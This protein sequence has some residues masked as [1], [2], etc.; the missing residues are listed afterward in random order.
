MQ[1]DRRHRAD[2]RSRARDGYRKCADVGK[3]KG[4]ILRGLSARAPYFHN[5]AAK[6]LD[7][8]VEFIT[9]ASCLVHRPAK[10]KTWLRSSN[11]VERV[12][13]PGGHSLMTARLA[14]LI[15]P[16]LGVPPLALFFS[17]LTKTFESFRPVL[18]LEAC[19][20]HPLGGGS[21]RYTGNH[22]LK[23]LIGY[24][25]VWRKR[26]LLTLGVA[27]LVI[28]GLGLQNIAR[29][30]RR[31][32]ARISSRRRRPSPSVEAQKVKW[33]AIHKCGRHG[34]RDP[35]C[36]RERRPSRKIDKIAFESG[37][38]VHRETSGRT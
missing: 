2:H 15:S 28:S 35:R 22:L 26:M 24:E 20:S 1:H 14:S 17:K 34:G 6:T 31:L 19:R 27:L 29:F 13:V 30:R 32:R 7:D 5:G 11:P 16:L 36:Y 9:S 18:N 10:R 3:T 12:L 38:S 21:G 23:H 25:D 4:P 8:A 33:P 37:K